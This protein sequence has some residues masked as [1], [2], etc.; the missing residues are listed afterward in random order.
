MDLLDNEDQVVATDLVGEGKK[1]RDLDALAKA[2]LEAD[3]HIERIERENAELR[4][5]FTKTKTVEELLEKL[6][7]KLGTSREENQPPPEKPVSKAAGNNEG[8]SQADVL[9]LVEG[10]VTQKEQERTRSQNIDHAKRELKASFGDKYA[11]VLKTKAEELGL[12]IEDMTAMAAK[13]P[14]ALI[15]LVSSS[16]SNEPLS[17]PPK[18]IRM[19]TSD[20]KGRDYAYYTNLRK[21][22]PKAYHSREVQWQMHKDAEKMGPSFYS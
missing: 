15:K 6:E 22:D 2:K 5:D 13:S 1:Y 17:S 16:K 12:T 10:H 4:Q 21:T 8:L 9:A 18:G 11:E 7:A 3:K 19:N 20:S 14:S